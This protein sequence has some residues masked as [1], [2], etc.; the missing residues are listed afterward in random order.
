MMG[1]TWSARRFLTVVGLVFA[2]CALW[3]SISAANVLSGTALAVSAM[4]LRIGT[5]A[6]GGLR[7][8]PFLTFVG[9][10]GLDLVLST[11]NVAREILTPTDYTDES[12]VAVQLPADSRRHLLLLVVA[13][14][15]T[16]GTAVVDTDADTGTLYLHLLHHD[17]REA[18]LAH[19]DR[20][21]QLACAALPVV[22]PTREV[23]A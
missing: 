13:V 3:G 17:R 19:V 2:W 15:V 12:I 6:S 21:A 9:L 10:V 22:E 8:V 14:T 18:T 11:F 5:R 23:P 4:G 7:L 16:P 20:L 1:V